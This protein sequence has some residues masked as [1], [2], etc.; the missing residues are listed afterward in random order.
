MRTRN[1]VVAALTPLFAL[2]ACDTVELVEPGGTP[3]TGG[4]ATVRFV[5][6]T[7]TGLDIAQS[8]VVGTGMSNITYGGSTSCFTVN[9]N[10]PAL[11]VRNTG[12]TTALS[13]LTTNFASNGSYTVLAYPDASGTTRFAV[14][15]NVYTP[16]TGQAGLRVFNAT[17]GTYDIYTAALG[18]SFVT[19]SATAVAAGS[20]SNFFNVTPGT[21]A[22][23][24]ISNAGTT[25]SALTLNNLTWTAGQTQTLVIAPP[26]AGSTTLRT[27]LVSGC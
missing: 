8:G 7:G 17:T 24:R 23:L 11:S 14:L 3:T 12:T 20:T 4:T 18:G 25:T 10:S 21:G 13:G 16:A 22:Q 5:N 6:A 15:P 2:A 26:V 19:P 1:F 27:F 9:A